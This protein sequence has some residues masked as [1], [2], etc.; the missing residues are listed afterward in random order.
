M[1]SCVRHLTTPFQERPPRRL[2][3]IDDIKEL[4]AQG[5]SDSVDRIVSELHVH[6][7]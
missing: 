5:D 3:Q 4:R 6:V 7:A 1:L 2:G